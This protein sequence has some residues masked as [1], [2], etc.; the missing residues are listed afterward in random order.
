MVFRLDASSHPQKESRVLGQAS[1]EPSGERLA[2]TGQAE[3]SPWR[4]CVGVC[5]VVCSFCA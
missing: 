3:L 4:E 1:V 2:V 5:G